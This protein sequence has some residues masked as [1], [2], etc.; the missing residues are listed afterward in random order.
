MHLVMYPENESLC[1]IIRSGRKGGIAGAMKAAKKI[2]NAFTTVLVVL[3]VILAILLVGVRVVGLKPFVVLSGS[4]EPDYPTGSLIYVKEV[5][6]FELEPGDV[7]TFMLNETTVATHR[8]VGIVPDEEDPSVIRFRTKGD[9]NDFEDGTLVHYKNVIGTPVFVIPL[10]G[11]VS[12]YISQP[13]G[14]F[15]A[16]IGLLLVILLMFVP[17]ILR[18]ADKADKK[19]AE[20]KAAEKKAAEA[21]ENDK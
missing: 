9:A 5:D 19:A 1:R 16:G 12:N 15:I 6:P 3:I 21:E 20:K 7:I 14:L 11:Y 10:L 18:A 2:W 8:M 17:D 13:P 4:M